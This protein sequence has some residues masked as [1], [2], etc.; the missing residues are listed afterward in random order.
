MTGET[1]TRLGLHARHRIWLGQEGSVGSIQVGFELSASE[2]IGVPQPSDSVTE[3]DAR[4]LYGK[5]WQLGWANSYVSTELGYR[6]RRGGQADEI[7]F[8]GTAGIEP[9][10][11]VLGL[12]TIAAAMP[13]GSLGDAKFEITPSLAF[14]LWPRV[15]ANDKKPDLANRPPVLQIG[16]GVDTLNVGNGIRISAGLWRWF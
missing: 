4:A 11:G 7:R 2:W 3:I 5:G 8:D 13:L 14:T 9:W 10:D 12:F 15:G 6:M 1:D 16:V